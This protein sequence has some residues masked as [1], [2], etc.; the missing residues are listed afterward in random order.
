MKQASSLTSFDFLRDNKD[1]HQLIDVIEN[2]AEA[3]PASAT[4]DVQRRLYTALKAPRLVARESLRVA[5]LVGGLSPGARRLSREFV[6]LFY[7]SL[8]FR[9]AGHL[10]W[11]RKQVTSAPTVTLRS[12]RVDINFAA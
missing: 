9:H 2:F 6:S 5:T 8:Y 1:W 12:S 3:L 4:I 7:N 10:L 11:V